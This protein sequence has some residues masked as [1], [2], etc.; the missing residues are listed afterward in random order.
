[1]TLF[2]SIDDPQNEEAVK[3]L[4]MF[5]MLAFA[6][7]SAERILPLLNY[8]AGYLADAQ[9]RAE[10]ANLYVKVAQMAAAGETPLGVTPAITYETADTNY[11]RSLFDLKSPEHESAFYAA[12]SAHEAGL[13][14]RLVCSWFSDHTNE[15]YFCK[16]IAGAATVAV[17]DSTCAA[18]KATRIKPSFIETYD[19]LMASVLGDYKTLLNL[20]QGEVDT[21]LVSDLGPL[22]K[23]EG[24]SWK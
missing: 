21:V 23:A 14:A 19:R 17:E 4:S 18:W 7:R 24:T 16:K 8:T 10:K 9:A 22:W 11:T 15:S 12:S 6:A 5:G 1:M 20:S 13:A 2:A 3:K